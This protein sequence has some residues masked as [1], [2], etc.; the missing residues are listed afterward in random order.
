MRIKTI[1]INNY[2]SLGNDDN[3]L[4]FDSDIITLIG[5]NETGKS[6]VLMALKEL[7]FFKPI[8]KSVFEDSNKFISGG[9]ITYRFEIE[10]LDADLA[11]IKKSWH[12]DKSTI[13]LLFEENSNNTLV[14]NFD[15]C[16]TGIM[17]ADP[18]FEDLQRRTLE[19]VEQIGKQHPTDANITNLRSLVQHS[20]SVYVTDLEY[21]GAFKKGHLNNDQQK[22]NRQTYDDF[23][24]CT[25]AYYD[26]Y[27]SILPVILNFDNMMLH[28]IYTLDELK[29]NNESLLKKDSALTRYLA[30][31][32]INPGEFVNA[33][34]ENQQN[35][36]QTLRNKINKRNEL[37]AKKFNEFYGTEK[38]GFS[39]SFDSKKYIFLITSGDAVEAF[40][41][42]ERSMGLRWFFSCFMELERSG[43]EKRALILIDEPGCHLHVNAQKKVLELFK[44]LAGDG[45][46][47]I[48]TTHS[49]YMID[50]SALSEIKVVTKNHYIT[51][52]TDLHK[53]RFE[54]ESE[55]ETLTPLA[56]A[57]DCDFCHNIGPSFKKTN[58]IV[59]GITDFYYLT[60]MF[61][62]LHVSEEDRPYVIPSCG[63]DNICRLVSIMIG[64]GCDFKVLYDSDQKGKEAAG[65]LG[66]LLTEKAEFDSRVFYVSTDA[67]KTIESLLSEDDTKKLRGSGKELKARMF[68]TSVAKEEL[69]PSEE[70]CANFKRLFERMSLKM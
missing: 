7:K 11:I 61:D 36:H 65:T 43:A 50:P 55:M 57:L 3:I 4:R 20:Q 54:G 25:Q 18:I 5:K 16:L 70:T 31:V 64:W 52:I 53:V 66:K 67:D 39:I 10:L 24:K 13:T 35:G 41:F 21:I 49:P 68:K 9:R 46:Q 22:K 37:L 44:S 60:A 14:M 58:V 26:A 15:G 59:E 62:V 56:R 63:A 32:N 30:A 45:R 38:I 1:Q 28:D 6:N 51:H 33:N 40:A 29:A 69:K 19:I 47:I 17:E 34:T 2:K 42:S 48:Y 27:S 8:V 12:T 23:F